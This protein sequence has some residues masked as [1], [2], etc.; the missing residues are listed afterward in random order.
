MI[1][2]LRPER[3]VKSYQ[4]EAQ[5][6]RVFLATLFS[7]PP[8]CV[9]LNLLLVMAFHKTFSVK[10]FLVM[11][12]KNH[13]SILQWIRMKSVIKSGPTPREDTGEEQG[14]LYKEPRLWSG[15]RCQG[16]LPFTISLWEHHYCLSSWLCFP[17]R[18]FFSFCWCF[19]FASMLV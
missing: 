2:Q 11:K 4:V 10:W 16:Y 9:Q 3:Q 5:K 12:Q 7:S 13:Q 1:L 18:W 8:S 17:G 6:T 15:T 19:F 14:W